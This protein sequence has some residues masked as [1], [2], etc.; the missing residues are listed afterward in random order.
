MFLT[1][2]IKHMLPDIAKIRKLVKR[3]KHLQDKMKAKE[4]TIWS[5]I[6]NLEESLRL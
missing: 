2:V 5:V 4:N 6:L 3:S 1:A